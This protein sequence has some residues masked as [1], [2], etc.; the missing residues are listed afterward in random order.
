MSR[1]PFQILVF[2]YRFLADGTLRYYRQGKALFYS[3]N[4][5]SETTYVSRNRQLSAFNS[6]GLGG[7]VAYTVK[8]VPGKYEVKL[9]GSYQYMRFKFSDFTDIRTGSL[10]AF[11]A[12]VLQLFVS[13]TF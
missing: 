9:N 5:Q 8:Q 2:P 6:I 11:N 3:D 12:N 13:A 10:Y 1:A 7:K 4:A